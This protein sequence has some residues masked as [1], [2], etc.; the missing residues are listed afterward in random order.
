VTELLNLNRRRLARLSLAI[1]LIVGA[2]P[3]VTPVAAQEAEGDGPLTPV[4]L[5]FTIVEEP[6]PGQE[7]VDAEGNFHF[8]GGIEIDTVSGSIEGD[9]TLTLDG[10]GMLTEGVTYL[11]VTLDIT[12]ENGGWDGHAGLIMVGEYE[13]QSIGAML[14]GRGD[15]AGKVIAIDTIVFEEEGSIT[16]SGQMLTMERP[17]VGVN[18]NY[19][20]CFTGTNTASGGFLAYAPYSD[21]GSASAEFHTV[22]APAPRVIFGNLT[23]QSERGTLNAMLVET[24]IEGTPHNFGSMMLMGGTGDYAN[25]YG[26]GYTN[27]TVS[28]G[29]DGGCAGPSGDFIGEAFGS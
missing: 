18:F 2:L 27:E 29:E 23:F 11:T 25:L 14:I 28:F 15:N 26:W 21:A 20:L 8:R 19:D 3:F 5:T 13:E 7:W 22:G 1:A 24:N 16:L 9:A 10:D 12:D 6:D 17:T 4:T